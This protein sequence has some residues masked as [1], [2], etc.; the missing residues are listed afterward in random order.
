MIFFLI[1]LLLHYYKL[2]II[3][4]Y[5]LHFLLYLPLKQL[6]VYKLLSYFPTFIMKMN[7]TSEI[8]IIFAV[9]KQ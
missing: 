7:G 3:L 1:I 2:L 4:L 5:L 6:L 8:M 9:E